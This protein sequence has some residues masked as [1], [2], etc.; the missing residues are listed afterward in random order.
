MATPIED[1]FE[2]IATY[3][4]PLALGYDGALG[5][6]DDAALVDLP[7]GE[8]LVATCDALVAG[9]HF[10][11]DDPAD[12]IARKALRVNLSDLASM[13]ARPLVYLL[14]LILPRDT[15]AEWVA[16]FAAGLATDQAE[17]GVHLAGGDTV[18]SDG[19]LTIA[20]TALGSVVRGSEL[21][22]AGARA[23]DV[24][25]V[26]GQVGDAA[27]GLLVL[28]EEL[29]GPSAEAC[30]DLVARYRLPRPRLALG[31]RLVGLAHAAIDVSDGLVADAGHVCDASGLGAVLNGPDLP[32]SPAARRLVAADPSWLARL[33]AGGDDYELLFAVAEADAESV[34]DLA[35]EL[36]LPLS[37]IGRL[38]E[39]RSVRLLD[40]AGA[41]V[42]VGKGG[43]GHF[44]ERPA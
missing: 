44:R 4:A 37:P 5:L 35:G 9:V 10:L 8:R 6:E 41:E 40:A 33:A 23:G 34:A 42:E 39:G 21:R 20:I 2:L 7:P 43:W 30:A 18:A 27:L 11:P 15:E 36:D 13:G 29:E 25:Y 12:L 16:D 1:E 24:L 19:P 3:F 32:L 31:A 17:F 22:R 14:N 38:V 28:Q 26:S